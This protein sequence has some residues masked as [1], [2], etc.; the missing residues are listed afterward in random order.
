LEKDKILLT[1]VDKVKE[2][3][4]IFKTQSEAQKLRLKTF[5]SNWPKLKRS[6]PLQKLNE[7]LANN[8]QII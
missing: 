1:L 6:A 5:G 7:E 2:D 8:G 4:A 3:E